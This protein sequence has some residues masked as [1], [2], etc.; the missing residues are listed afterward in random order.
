MECIWKVSL[1]DIFNGWG[2]LYLFWS[3]KRVVSSDIRFFKGE[4]GGFYFWGGL[5]SIYILRLD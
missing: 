1:G 4:K 2:L 3:G 5:L